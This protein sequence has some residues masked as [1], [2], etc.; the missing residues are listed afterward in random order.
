MTIKESILKSLHDINKLT[1]YLKIFNHI[2]EKNITSTAKTVLA[3]YKSDT[4]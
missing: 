4:M 1:N 2:V 3:P